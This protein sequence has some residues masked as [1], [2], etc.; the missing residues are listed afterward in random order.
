MTTDW[1]A[2]RL[3]AYS[4]FKAEGFSITVRVPGSDGTWNPTTMAYTGGTE[5]AD[6]T[7]YALKKKYSIRDIDGTT[8]QQN[9]TQL[10]FPAYGANA[11]GTLGNLPTLSTENKILISSVEQNVINLVPLDPGNVP[12]IYTAQVRK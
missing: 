9:D 6:Y 2:E 8:V 12:I 11:A 10:L 7:T 4:A 1:A 5:D 3:S